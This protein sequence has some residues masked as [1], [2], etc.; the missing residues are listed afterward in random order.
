MT[1]VDSIL[2]R[3]KSFFKM[4]SNDTNQ[5]ERIGNSK[6]YLQDFEP[7]VNSEKYS[8]EKSVKYNKTRDPKVK[9]E[10]CLAI[11]YIL[12]VFK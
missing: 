3:I 12:L 5:K 2:H 9:T 1:H 4:N 10:S 11:I 7:Y 6:D 8:K